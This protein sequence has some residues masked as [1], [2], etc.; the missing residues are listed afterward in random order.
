MYISSLGILYVSDVVKAQ[1][2]RINLILRLQIWFCRGN[3]F[4]DQCHEVDPEMI[5][6]RIL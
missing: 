1:F 5:E 6:T 2:E 3:S 4:K